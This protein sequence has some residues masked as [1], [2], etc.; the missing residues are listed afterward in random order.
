MKWLEQCSNESKPI[1]Y[2][3]YVD[4]I[5]VLSVEHLSQ[6]HAY[7]NSCHPNMYFSFEPKTN[8]K[9]SFLKVEVSRKVNL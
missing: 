5:F 4:Y 6:F 9:L 7:L 2:R 8:G 3:R 1:F